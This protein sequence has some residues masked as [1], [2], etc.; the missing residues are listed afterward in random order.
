MRMA[1]KMGN[2]RSNISVHDRL[3]LKAKQQDLKKR[4]KSSEK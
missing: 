4:E 3:Y 2:S 1:E